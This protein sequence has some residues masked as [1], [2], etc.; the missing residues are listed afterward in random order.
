MLR[1][2]AY[3]AF[4]QDDWK[5]TPRLTLN[6]GVRYENNRPWYDKYRGIMNVQMF[7][8]GVGPNGLL[9]GTQVPILTRPGSGDFYE[10]LNFR[11]HD[12]IPVQAGDQYLGRSLVNPDNNDLAPRVGISYSPTD[13]WTFRTGYGLFY[14]K[15]AG[16]PVFDMAR[17]MA[18]RGFIAAD[19]ERPNANLSDPWKEQREQFTCTGW[20]GACLGPFQVL[21]NIVGRR[22]PYVHQWLFNVQRQL[23]PDLMLEVGYQGNAGHKLERFRTYNQAILKTGPSDARSIAQ[24]R[25]WP[26]YDRIQQVD[27]SVNS[28]YHALAG[29]LQQRFSRGLTYLASFT[30]SKAIDS[31]SA[32]RTNSGDRLW[33]TNSYDLAAERGLSQF[34]V[35]RRFAGSAVYELPFGRGRTFA[36]EP[37]IVSAI[38]GG[39]Q[40][41][42]ILT[43]A[44]GAPTNVGNIGDSFAVGGLGNVPHATGVS[45]IPSNR[46]PDNFWNVASFDATNPNLS[47]LAGNA[48][49]NVLF[50]PGTRQL[51]ASLT[52]NI[53]V[54]EGHTLQFRWESFN[55][56]NHPN[57]NTPST[58]AR[59]AATFGKVTS[60][61]TMREMQFALK[62]LF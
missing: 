3:Y 28:N 6:I 13:Q 26:A 54:R 39:W 51:D 38:I 7:D 40:I 50:K 41:G 16:N 14:T 59:N 62:Y 24:R 55:A 44:D 33:P 19:I 1:G 5:I 12:S 46:S 52:R 11:F 20:A 45:P 36:S 43:L 32:L 17:N 4:F 34:H 57:W 21:G 56:T 60:A 48:G 49:R 58:D 22:T 47:Y 42:G 23:T 27:G 31:G 61:R 8:P 18:G 2:T 25:P 53:Q 10:D 30:W 37:G 15:D 35:G 29:K 9:S